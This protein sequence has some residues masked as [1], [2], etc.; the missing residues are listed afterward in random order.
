MLCPDCR[1]PTDHQETNLH[2]K[3]VFIQAGAQFSP[4]SPMAVDG[5][6]KPQACKILSFQQ[7][8]DFPTWQ[9]EDWLTFIDLKLGTF[10]LTSN[11]LS[12]LY[13]IVVNL[14]YLF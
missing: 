7:G 13:V 2:A 1:V 8:M 11:D 3:A 5:C 14:S 4:I 9:L 12:L 6:R 10:L